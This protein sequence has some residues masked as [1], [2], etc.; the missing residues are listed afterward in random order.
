MPAKST[1]TATALA[2]VA[3]L[4][5]T[6]VLTLPPTYA[7]KIPPA[8]TGSALRKP[9][10]EE[11]AF[12]KAFKAAQT[13][14]KAAASKVAEAKA[15]TSKLKENHPSSLEPS[16]VNKVNTLRLNILE[17]NANSIFQALA[18]ARRDAVDAALKNLTDAYEK[19]PDEP[20][21]PLPTELNAAMEG[22]TALVEEMQAVSGSMDEERVALGRE[23]NKVDKDVRTV[24]GALKDRAKLLLELKAT[25]L[26]PRLAELLPDLPDTL[27]YY[28][29]LADGISTLVNALENVKDSDDKRFFEPGII[30]SLRTAI[31]DPALLLKEGLTKLPERLED[32]TSFL[33]KEGEPGKDALNRLLEKP[34]NGDLQTAAQRQRR[35][36][37]EYRKSAARLGDGLTPLE[38]ELLRKQPDGVLPDNGTTGTTFIAIIKLAMDKF[39]QQRISTDIL[40]D[41]LEKTHVVNPSTWR[42]ERVTLYYFDDVPRLLKMLNP[43]ASLKGGDTDAAS[44]AR[45]LREELD[46]QTQAVSEARQRLNDARSHL[47]LMRARVENAQDE[48]DKAEEETDA[49]RKTLDEKKTTERDLERKLN[50]AKSNEEDAERAEQRSRDRLKEAEE[51]LA[52]DP[53]NAERKATVEQR[54]K[55]QDAAVLRTREAAQKREKAES[56]LALSQKETALTATEVTEKT[57]RATEQKEKVEAELKKA[58]EAMVTAETRVREENN[59]LQTALTNSLLTA[60]KEN[61]AFARSR[62]NA[63]YWVAGPDGNDTDPTRRV[64]LFGF[65]DSKLV[66][67]RGEPDDVARTLKIIYSFDRPQAQAMLHLWTLEISDEYTGRKKDKGNDLL[68]QMVPFVE[69]TLNDL[70]YLSNGSINLFKDAIANTY[71]I[72]GETQV[73]PMAPPMKTRYENIKTTLPEVSIKFFDPVVIQGLGLLNLDLDSNKQY[74]DDPSFQAGESIVLSLLPSGRPSTLAE[75]L[76]LFAL[77]SP[78]NQF[79]ILKAFEDSLSTYSEKK[80]KSE[81][82]TGLS[83]T[84]KDRFRHLKGYIGRATTTNGNAITESTFVPTSTVMA[85]RDEMIAEIR[86]NSVENVTEYAGRLAVRWEEALRKEDAD[87]PQGGRPTRSG[88]DA[89]RERLKVAVDWL[90][91]TLRNAPI[92]LTKQGVED[93]AAAIVSIPDVSKRPSLAVEIRL[94]VERSMTLSPTSTNQTNARVA[95]L[96]NLL[97]QFIGAVDKDLN[98]MYISPVV[99][100]MRNTLITKAVK[101]KS[102]LQLGIIQRT[103]LLASNRTLSRVDPS[104]SASVEPTVTTASGAV[105]DISSAVQLA[106]LLAGVPL[107]GASPTALRAVGSLASSLGLPGGLMPLPGNG[108]T[109]GSNV[110]GA[111]PPPPAPTNGNEKEKKDPKQDQAFRPGV[112]AVTGGGAFAVTPVFDPS[113]QALRFRFDYVHANQVREPDNTTSRQFSRV[114]RQSVN[115]EVQLSNFEARIIT[116]YQSSVKLGL[117]A[118]RTGGLPILKNIPG[119]RDVPFLGWFTK[120][121]ETRPVVMESLIFAQTSMYPTIDDIIHLLVRPVVER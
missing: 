40:C 36:L 6:V 48:M 96:N 35:Q 112:Y 41:Q 61:A 95:A 115:T 74:Q 60:M 71:Q 64:M 54:R 2:A 49:A 38:V 98:E 1:K 90:G 101:D 37:E 42:E 58:E 69:A 47:E 62:D 50:T 32:A 30:A 99:D 93:R 17:V 52:K 87:T 7:D 16:T 15:I 65:P 31:T 22:Y 107:G 88:S 79:K 68:S 53:E 8:S 57:E 117:P 9:N 59:K 109:G 11:D 23:V 26:M 29:E 21:K 3:L 44:N 110:S 19:L 67:V 116:S 114:D 55:D 78:V 13:V 120:R 100:Q 4:S 121:D 46:K 108:Q 111:F 34:R 45:T 18:P 25:T 73:G 39:R 20:K 75:A 113:G 86:R 97:K 66:F 80:F 119:I 56:E 12:I 118:T 72:P 10:K 27:R 103:T 82:L 70:S 81:L 28:R 104:F 33:A 76:V 85:F 24:M 105:G 84:N 63:P 51:A 94:A 92:L 43:D 102:A 91:K 106:G 89:W 14:K 5:V 83:P 77:A